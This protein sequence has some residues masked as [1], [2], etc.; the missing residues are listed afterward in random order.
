MVGKRKPLL[1]SLLRGKDTH[2]R[3]RSGT[4][5]EIDVR[6]TPGADVGARVE[7]DV[8]GLQLPGGVIHRAG[9]EG[10]ALEVAAPP[11]G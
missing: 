1:R 3:Y 7:G 9:G 8:L 5:E 11:G 4:P 2:G 6:V 10:H